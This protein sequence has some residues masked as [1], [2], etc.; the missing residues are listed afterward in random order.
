M[1]AEI[2][3]STPATLWRISGKENGWMNVGEQFNECKVNE[4]TII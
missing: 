3:S 1:S 2:G 4:Q